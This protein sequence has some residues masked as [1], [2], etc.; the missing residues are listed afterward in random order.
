[1]KFSKTLK[2]NNKLVTYR[3]M[4][5]AEHIVLVK[6]MLDEDGC[7]I[8]NLKNVLS[9]IT[10]LTRKELQDLDVISLLLLTLHVRS[11]S[12]SNI[13]DVDIKTENGTVKADIPIDRIILSLQDTQQKYYTK[14]YIISEK[15]KAFYIELESPTLESLYAEN[16][17]PR[18]AKLNGS[19]VTDQEADLLLSKLS[20]ATGRFISQIIKEATIVEPVDL[21]RSSENT[22]LHDKLFFCF[23]AAVC[24]H[25]LRLLF[26]RDLLA[27]YDGMFALAKNCNMSPQYLESITPGEYL[28][29]LRQYE[30]I[31]AQNKAQSPQVVE[32]H[33]DIDPDQPYATSGVSYPNLPPIISTGIS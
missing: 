31:V 3:E 4:N 1:M 9:S 26:N 6:S 14:Q 15:L 8:Q 16:V 12:I 18:I 22:E 23:N 19:I 32:N 25:L 2:L 28:I 5:V 33:E 27:L 11:I 29:Y 7:F 21:L 17:Q 13:I 20:A 10:N 24:I 30:N